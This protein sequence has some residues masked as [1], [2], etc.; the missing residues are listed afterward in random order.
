MNRPLYQPHDT[1]AIR[2]ELENLE[3]FRN[4]SNI[5]QAVGIAVSTNPYM[6]SSTRDQ[7]LVV[8]GILLEYYSGGSLQ[9]ILSEHRLLEF[10][11]EQWALQIATALARF[12]KAGKTHMDIKPANVVI[13]A[14]GNAMLIDISGIGGVT[15]GWR[16]PEIQD[17]ILPSELP[18]EVRR[19]SDTW[20]YG[21]LL[22]QLVL[23]AEDNCLGRAL[24]QIAGDLMIEDMHER[25]DLFEVI[26][27]L[28]RVGSGKIHGTCGSL[29]AAR[30]V[31]I[32]KLCD[33]QP[34]HISIRTTCGYPEPPATE[35]WAALGQ[36]PTP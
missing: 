2:K 29:T 7:S 24:K 5:V 26:L 23:H 30:L 33:Q 21:K 9:T 3:I 4:E 8:M 11:W 1:E 34:S 10:S 12:H 22:L 13:D 32:T 31:H 18:Y 28:E 15:H 27:R 19:S 36:Q 14:D 6:T 25:M 17:Q 35:G 20:T 16:A